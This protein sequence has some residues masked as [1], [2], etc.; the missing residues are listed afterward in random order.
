[1]KSASVPSERVEGLQNEEDGGLAL[2]V[3]GVSDVSRRVLREDFGML[4]AGLAVVKPAVSDACSLD[5]G[6]KGEPFDVDSSRTPRDAILLDVEVE[7]LGLKKPL[8][9]C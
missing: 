1:M 8:R 6:S 3:V 5:V 4:G 9:D 2:G 7:A